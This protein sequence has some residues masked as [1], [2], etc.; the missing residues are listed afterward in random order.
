MR[1]GEIMALEWQDVDVTKRQLTVAR[2]DWKGHV[3]TPM[4]GKL[5]HVPLTGRLAQALRDGRH[6]RGPRVLLD[7]ERRP[8]TQKVIQGL[9]RRVARR[10][11]VETGVH[12]LRH[13]FCSHLGHA[14]SAR[15]G[16][17]G[18]GLTPGPGDDAAVYAS[19]ASRL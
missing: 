19:V 13:T 18:T 17:P 15:S 12:T 14:G 2:S 5:R 9:V 3:T 7:A 16:H 6:L 8:L 1:C 11:R 4:G 10:A